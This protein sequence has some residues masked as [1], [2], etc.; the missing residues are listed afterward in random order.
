MP[1]VQLVVCWEAESAAARWAAKRIRT[2]FMVSLNFCAFDFLLEFGL[3]FDTSMRRCLTYLYPFDF[4]V[5]RVSS[6]WTPVLE[7]L[8]ACDHLS[9]IQLYLG[10][11]HPFL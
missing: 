4:F 6:Q 5:T 3:Y 9:L 10:E 8:N 7:I 2:V 1:V 11:R